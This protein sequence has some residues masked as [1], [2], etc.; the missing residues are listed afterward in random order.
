[1][2]KTP[3]ADASEIDAFD[4]IVYLDVVAPMLIGAP[5]PAY[6]DGV[7]A[8]LHTAKSMAEKVFAVE[9]DPDVCDLAGVFKVVSVDDPAAAGHNGAAATK[10]DNNI[11]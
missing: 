4:P 6:R 8:N 10:T 7:L 2:S 1:M 11:K 5:D 3:R 9:L